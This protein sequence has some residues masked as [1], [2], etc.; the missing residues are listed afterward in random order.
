MPATK[1]NATRERLGLSDIITSEGTASE[2][3]AR[4]GFHPDGE[5]IG[6]ST[7]FK[8]DG[9]GIAPNDTTGSN[10]DGAVNARHLA[11]HGAPI[12]DIAADPFGSD[13]DD[14][15]DD[16]SHLAP[17]ERAAYH[18]QLKQREFVEAFG[19]FADLTKP[20]DRDGLIARARNSLKRLRR[21]IRGEFERDVT[22]AVTR[23]D[24]AAA[25]M[26]EW[27]ARQTIADALS[28]SASTV[29]TLTRRGNA[30]LR[31][32]EAV[33]RAKANEQPDSETAPSFGPP[34][35]YDRR[36][37]FNLERATEGTQFDSGGFRQAILS[38][39]MLAQHDIVLSLQRQSV[40]GALEAGGKAERRL[41]KLSNFELDAL[42][43]VGRKDGA[44]R[45][46]LAQLDEAHRKTLL[47]DWLTETTNAAIA[48]T[49]DQ[50]A[51]ARANMSTEEH[52]RAVADL[53]EQ[54]GRE[55]YRQRPCKS[56]KTK[57]ARRY[58]AS[59]KVA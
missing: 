31:L 33:A 7:Q 29:D 28:C 36:P 52:H 11:G 13:D 34:V 54:S 32:A 6:Q 45:R 5:P 18:A 8:P 42:D 44:T 16:L 25:D 53:L 2:L 26:S 10:L 47:A 21:G 20:C 22:V 1:F 58:R 30:S 4:H 3:L 49:A 40:E 41:A 19:F 23:A 51:T 38:L 59:R 57:M 15:Y 9:R 46:M 12:A 14:G 39:P 17:Q 24:L 55:S 50:R 43:I 35:E 56:L 27:A 37:E 48:G